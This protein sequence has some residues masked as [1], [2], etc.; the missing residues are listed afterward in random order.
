MNAGVLLC[1]LLG[2]L[3]VAGVLYMLF[4]G[5]SEP[6]LS[7]LTARLGAAPQRL[8]DEQAR[9]VRLIRTKLL[10]RERDFAQALAL[11]EQSLASSPDSRRLHAWR[12][13]LLCRSKRTTE[14][15]EVALRALAAQDYAVKAGDFNRRSSL[16]WVDR[17]LRVAW[18]TG[19]HHATEALWRELTRACEAKRQ[20]G[21][22]ELRELYW[23]AALAWCELQRGSPPRARAVLSA[24]LLHAQRFEGSQAA[25]AA[26]LIKVS[27]RWLRLLDADDPTLARD[28]ESW[29]SSEF[30]PT[31]KGY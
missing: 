8:S 10:A 30:K 17:L 22:L 5:P 31:T 26:V 24:L 7:A 13:S 23:R 27:A 11:V 21:G 12:A 1:L 3:P 15:R 18:S 28:L 29:L 2:L 4:T 16:K 14:A 19:R 20:H 25:P 9:R 6:T